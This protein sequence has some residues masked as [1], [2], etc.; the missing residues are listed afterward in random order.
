ML[1]G[2]QRYCENGEHLRVP[3]RVALA[4]QAYRTDSDVI[5]Q[6]INDRCI[7]DLNPASVIARSALYELYV[8]WCKDVGEDSSNTRT[9]ANRL[10]ERGVT[11]K[12]VMGTRF[13][14]GIREM[15]AEEIR[16]DVQ[17]TLSD[18]S[19]E[20]DVKGTRGHI[21]NYIQKFPYEKEIEEVQESSVE[22]PHLPSVRQVD[23]SGMSRV[24]LTEILIA[25]GNRI[26]QIG[27]PEAFRLAWQAAGGSP[28]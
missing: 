5:G 7:L 13:W 1:E 14:V 12:K 26:D 18:D 20:Q 27:D 21:G 24:E 15:T 10:Q 8:A 17:I 23:Y 6:F 28:T 22:V 11:S 16:Q 4:T 9:F 19:E 3:E 2:L 25:F